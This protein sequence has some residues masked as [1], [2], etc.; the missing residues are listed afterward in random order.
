MNRL[1]DL[2]DAVGGSEGSISIIAAVLVHEASIIIEAMGGAG[3]AM[4][5]GLSRLCFSGDMYVFDY[6]LDHLE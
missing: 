5:N 3:G 2:S 4:T 1:I 6:W